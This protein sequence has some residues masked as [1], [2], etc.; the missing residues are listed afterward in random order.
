MWWRELDEVENKCTSH[1]FNLFAIFL[2]KIIKKVM[3]Q[4]LHFRGQRGR[5]LR[6]VTYF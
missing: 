4:L 1:I 5:G 3:T 6:H 2:P